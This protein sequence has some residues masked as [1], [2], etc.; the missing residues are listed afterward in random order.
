VQET[1]SVL[2]EVD[3][4]GIITFFFDLFIVASRKEKHLT[5]SAN[6]NGPSKCS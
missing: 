6:T 5:V 1:W 2:K 4:I 3:E